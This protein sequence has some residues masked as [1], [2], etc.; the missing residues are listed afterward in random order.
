MTIGRRGVRRRYAA[1]ALGDLDDAIERFASAV[2]LCIARAAI[3]AGVECRIALA[4][5]LNARRAPGDA[6]AA[7][8]TLDLAEP[9]AIRLAMIPICARIAELRVH[10]DRGTGDMGA[11]AD[12]NRQGPL[13]VREAEVAELVLWE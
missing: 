11:V 8:A 9:T 13:S 10:L 12:S 3:P 5:A 6:D 4:E 1:Q 7:R 2:K